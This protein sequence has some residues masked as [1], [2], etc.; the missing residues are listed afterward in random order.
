MK[1]EYIILIIIVAI[2]I[3]AGIKLTGFNVFPGGELGKCID[4][5]GGKNLTIQGITKYENREKE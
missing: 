3:I 1:K 4:T 5:D 2:T